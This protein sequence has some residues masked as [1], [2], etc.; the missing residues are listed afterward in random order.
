MNDQLLE[1]QHLY[2]KNIVEYNLLSECRSVVNLVDVRFDH[3]DRKRT[4]TNWTQL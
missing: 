4:L 1:F 2:I 3:R